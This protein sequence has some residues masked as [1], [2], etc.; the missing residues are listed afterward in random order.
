MAI[1]VLPHHTTA[2][3]D[4][5]MTAYN[6]SGIRLAAT[7]A[8]IK[9]NG[10]LDLVLIEFNPGTQ[11][12]AVFT[13][14]AFCAAPVTLAR[15]HLKRGA[16]RALLINAGN[17]NAGTGDRG[18]K[19]A[20]FCC[21]MVASHLG[22]ETDEV[23]PFSTGVIG[24]YLP[25][26]K[27]QSALPDL[28][29]V[30]D[31]AAWP[32]AAAGIMTTDT[33]PKLMS[34]TVTIEGASCRITGMAKGSGMIKPNMATLLTFLATDALIGRDLLQD[35]LQHAVGLSFNRI[36]VDGDTSTNDSCLLVAT[37]ANPRFRVEALDSA[38]YRAFSLALTELCQELA[39]EC[40]RDGEGATRLVT[41][42]VNAA[43]NA[44]EAETVATTVAHSPLVKTALFA[45]DPNWGRILAAVGRS[46]VENLDVRKVDIYLDDVLIAEAGARATSYR[47]AAAKAVMDKPEYQI[48]IQLG[49]GTGSYNIWTCDFSYDYVKI[50]AEYRS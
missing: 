25:T 12:A 41:V 40:V 1:S 9:K 48:R 11:A 16:P 17:A 10:K 45:A 4:E 42:Q 38:S 5:N 37:G 14:N 7:R 13:R 44:Q 8:G 20:E 24:E 39:K 46:G 36:T 27:V 28:V 26:E 43:K 47:E 34:R 32:Q 29:A 18:L 30:L 3:S 21:A 35:C 19:D 23:I 49:R 6:I 2:T 33:R 50:N 31:E 22:C 15:D